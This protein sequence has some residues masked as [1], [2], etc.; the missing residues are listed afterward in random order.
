[1]LRM[2]LLGLLILLSVGM[3]SAMELRAPPRRVAVIAE[4]PTEQTTSSSASHGALAKADRLESAAVSSD[5]AIQNPSAERL[6]IA[7]LRSQ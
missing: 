2:A 6:W 1:M 5:E 4:P 3:L 7:S